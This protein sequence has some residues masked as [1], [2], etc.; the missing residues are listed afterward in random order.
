MQQFSFHD[1]DCGQRFISQFKMKQ[2]SL[3]MTIQYQCTGTRTP[4]PQ[5]CEMSKTAPAGTAT[6]QRLRRHQ[7]ERAPTRARAAYVQR[8][9]LRVHVPPET[10]APLKAFLR[11][12]VCH[13][14][15]IAGPGKTVLQR[16]AVIQAI[17]RRF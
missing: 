13:W 5:D 11:F 6:R 14:Y 3:S 7:G 10:A 8:K 2:W 9:R 17:R 15:T 1:V 16:A 4:L 12:C